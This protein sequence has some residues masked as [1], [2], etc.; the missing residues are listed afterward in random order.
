MPINDPNAEERGNLQLCGT[1]PQQQP[2]PQ[3]QPQPAQ[4]QPAPQQP[5]PET[6]Q[7]KDEAVEAMT[8]RD[9]PYEVTA[10]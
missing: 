9:W 8:T 5:Q 7:P 4:P 10:E 6:D 3:Q 1:Q 2:K